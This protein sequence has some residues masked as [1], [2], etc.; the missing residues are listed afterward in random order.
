MILRIFRIDLPDFQRFTSDLRGLIFLQNM[1]YQVLTI[2]QQK[3]AALLSKPQKEFNRLTKKIAQLQADVKGFEEAIDKAHQRVAKDLTPLLREHHER[4]AEIVRLMDRAFESGKFKS[5][6]QKKLA[7]I[8]LEI[9]YQL[10]SEYD[11]ADLKPIYDKYADVNYDETDGEID[12]SAAAF[13]R[14]VF[15]QMFGIDIPDDAD[16]STP[17]KMQAYLADHMEQQE[18]AE[19]ERQRMAEERRAQRPRTAKQ[20]EREQ[21]KI[22]KERKKAEEEAKVTKSVREVYLDL[23]KAF[24][25]DRE[26]EEAE[27]Q[28]KTEIMQRITDAYERNDLLGLLQLQLELE[29]IDQDHLETIA[30]ERLQHFNKILR[31][32]A[33]ELDELLWGIKVSLSQITSR[34]P[35]QINNPLQIAYWLDVDIK[36]IRK[37]VRQ[38]EQDFQDWSDPKELRAWLKGYKIRKPSP[39]DFLGDFF[40]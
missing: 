30:E 28:R 25:P 26:P 35:Y 40:A 19:L 34:E 38:L 33:A 12:E 27:R 23:V 32:Q 21:K 3:D 8:I 1:T 6:E 9:A 36:R 11:M 31:K 22:E 14:E 13:A 18:K 5:Q 24:H 16:V 20:M 2:G 37:E 10:I 15:G 29:R 4:R 39:D 7:H 17:E